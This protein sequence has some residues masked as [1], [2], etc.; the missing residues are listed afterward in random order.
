M[1]WWLLYA[2]GTPAPN[3][4]LFVSV[5]LDRTLDPACALGAYEALV[6]GPPPHHRFAL[7]TRAPQRVPHTSPPPSP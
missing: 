3:D 2:W 5:T 7:R 6:W 1:C 4:L